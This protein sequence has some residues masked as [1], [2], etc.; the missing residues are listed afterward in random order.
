MKR[1]G[2]CTQIHMHGWPYILF[3]G[4][5]HFVFF[6]QQ[7][8]SKDESLVI[9][10]A[11]ECVYETYDKRNLISSAWA[12]VVHTKDRIS[13]SS[14]NHMSGPS[15]SCLLRDS[16]EI[17][18]LGKPIPSIQTIFSSLLLS[19]QGSHV[20]LYTLTSM[21]AFTF[22]S[23]QNRDPP[24]RHTNN[25]ANDQ[26]WQSKLK[27]LQ[28]EIDFE[29]N[30]CFVVYSPLRLTLLSLFSVLSIKNIHKNCCCENKHLKTT[31]TRPV[32]YRRAL[33]MNPG[34]WCFINTL[35]LPPHSPSPRPLYPSCY[36][37]SDPPAK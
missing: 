6:L 7:I 30:R 29:S 27:R 34:S 33:W 22:Q 16:E 18:L 14:H 28:K 36:K 1:P 21:F 25:A 13:L 19:F 9:F 8:T 15:H 35:D 20:V 17:L 23:T 5:L 12:A 31:T 32:G 3:S 4:W 24:V 2:L 37:T 11:R 10:S 26:S